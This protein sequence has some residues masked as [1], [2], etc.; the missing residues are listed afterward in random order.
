LIDIL[1]RKSKSQTIFL[2]NG[3]C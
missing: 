2:W 3:E 1:E